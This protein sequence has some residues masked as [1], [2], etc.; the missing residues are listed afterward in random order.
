MINQWTGISIIWRG[1]WALSFYV[2]QNNYFGWNSKPQSDVELIVDGITILLISLIF[3]PRATVN[4]NINE[5]WG[6]NYE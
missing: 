2:M 4:V 5:Q 6:K 1:L 3:L